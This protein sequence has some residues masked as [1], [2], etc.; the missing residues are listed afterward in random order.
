MKMKNTRQELLLQELREYEAKASLSKDERDALREW[1]KNGNSIHENPCMAEDGHGR[2]LDFID[3]Y[4][5]NAE[6]GNILDSLTEKER[7][8][9][10]ARLQR[11]ATIDDLR[12][13]LMKMTFRM[14]CYEDVL[15]N[16]GLLD[17]ALEYCDSRMAQESQT[18]VFDNAHDEPLPFD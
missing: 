9:Y 15:R 14:N 3:V 1:V 13:D 7:E 6:L 10:L 16:Y 17:K 11:V 12:D 4:R 5:T 18:S 2:Y 8:N